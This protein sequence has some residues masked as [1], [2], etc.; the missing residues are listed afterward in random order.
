MPLP[1]TPLPQAPDRKRPTTFADEGDAFLGA[2]PTFGEEMAA[3][4]AQAEANAATAAI[5]AATATSAAN[6]ATASAISAI[7]APGTNATSTTSM[8][9]GTGSKSLTVQTGKSFVVGQ[10]VV[11]ASTASPTNYMIGQITAYTS[12]TGAL[13][14]NVTSTGGSGT[15]AAWTISICA[16]GFVGGTLTSA[17][18]EAPQVTLASAATVDIGAA[19]ANT[20]NITGTTT[21]TS[22]GTDTPGA[23]RRLVFAASLTV[24]HNGTSLVLP[25]ATSLQVSAGDVLEVVSLG[26]G[27][28]RFI[29]YTPNVSPFQGHYLMVSQ[30]II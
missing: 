30:G 24:V 6:S 28:W 10:F 21:I 23:M 2:L 4:G 25:G 7:N 29:G 16:P 22:F 26:S 13:V 5:D 15:Q 17:L 11:I 3:I 19:A 27:N 8:T 1:Y 9:V 14:V 18:D 20:I 12:G